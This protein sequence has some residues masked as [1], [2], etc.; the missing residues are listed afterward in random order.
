MADYPSKYTG[1]Q[2]DALLDLVNERESS[3]RAGSDKPITAGGA[4]TALD[5]K[6]DSS[7]LAAVATSGDYNALNNKPAI[8]TR[9]SQLSSDTT[10]QT[11][12]DAEKATWN[13][14]QNAIGDLATIRS[15][16]SK[17][18]T[19]YQKPSTGIPKSDL[20][21]AVQASLD[22]A[23]ST[24]EN[25]YTKAQTDGLL[26][27]KVDKVAG[28]GL[29]TNDYTD[30]EKTKLAALPTN[31]ELNTALD[32]KADKVAGATEGNL[33]ALDENG[34]LKDSGLPASDVAKEDGYYSTLVAGA[35]ENLVGRGTVGA[36]YTRRKT[37]GNTDV[38]DSTALIKALKGRSIVWNQLLYGFTIPGRWRALYSN[39]TLT[40]GDDKVIVSINDG[41]A[42]DTKIMAYQNAEIK[43]GHK[44]YLSY[45]YYLSGEST[46]V[47]VGFFRG[48][49]QYFASQGAG[50]VSNKRETIRAIIS[51]TD[52]HTGI[53]IGPY[54]RTNE[55]IDDYI[56]FYNIKLV[57]L[58]QMFGAGNEPATAEE[59]EALFP[60]PYYEQNAGTIINNKANGIET[61]GFNL[62]D[63]DSV[64][65][66][67]PG[68]TKV[69]DGWSGRC[70]SF[71]T[72]F[73]D[74][75][76]NTINYQGQ[77]CV[78]F[79]AHGESEGNF[80][81]RFIYTDG[82]WTD[83][84]SMSGERYDGYGVSVAGK[85]VES[86]IANY[87]TSKAIT[88]ERVCISFYDSA[89][90]GE[91]ETFW[92]NVLNLL[93]PTLTGKK[94]GTGESVI[95]C[96]DGLRQAESARDECIVE[97]GYI[98]KIVRRIA[99]V[100]LG[101]HNNVDKY[102]NASGK[103]SFWENITGIKKAETLLS[104]GNILCSKYRNAISHHAYGI[105]GADKCISVHTLYQRVYIADSDY[106]SATAEEFKATLQGVMLNYEL[107]TPETFILDTPV[108]V[109]Y[110]VDGLGMESVLPENGSTPTTAPIA[111][112]VA[113]PFN[114]V[115]RLRNLGKNFIG[116]DSM[117]HILSAFQGAGIIGG[118]TLTYN[119]ETDNYACTI[120]PPNNE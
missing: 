97:N 85:K 96:P 28:K 79:K 119:S 38:G 86:I 62:L 82:T 105:E 22:K 34:N 21:S 9:L 13:G 115:D 2:V 17:G 44:Y 10:H 90:N 88:I 64:L 102:T 84:P 101:N 6:A 48:P 95:V 106:A 58:T 47:Y 80:R 35:A 76:K 89:R 20:S 41:S 40:T 65:T 113:Y 57:D 112:D 36:E 68:I 14:K 94:D 108:Y 98:T 3:P 114:A 71:N 61:T 104:L 8:P 24:A 66:G 99:C 111:Y 52:D 31:A 109:G 26:N 75:W 110:R 91:Y 60:L 29:S 81:F 50:F 87:S 33:A 7:S 93:I 77:M 42:A 51:S 46:Y 83:M 100:D 30:S 72:A 15:G 45:E 69:A 92:K 73:G 59:F 32:D 1:E 56:E 53:A 67:K 43:N 11:V 116:V 27:G 120:T 107:E 16:A 74:C 39:S 19:A 37:G 25:T 12:T 103:V 49:T 63:E 54:V 118:Y 55:S 78:Y 5:G 4:K 18:A 70:N 117:E 23:E